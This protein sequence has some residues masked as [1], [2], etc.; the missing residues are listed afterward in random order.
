MITRRHLLLLSGFAGT[1]LVVQGIGFLCGLLLLRVM[2]VTQ[3][4]IYTLAVSL[5]GVVAM[6]AD[7]GLTSAMLPQGAPCL[8]QPARLTQLLAQARTLSWRFGL[9]S[10]LLWPPVLVQLLRRQQVEPGQVVALALLVGVTAWLQ[11]QA[12]LAL[13][14]VRLL[15]HTRWQQLF[16]LTAQSIRLLVLLLISAVGASAALGLGGWRLD[17]TA[18]CAISLLLAAVSWLAVERHLRRHLG[19]SMR[20]PANAQ[21][22][23]HDDHRAGLLH[24]VRR[25]GPNTV[26]YI[27]NGQ[28]AVWLIGWFGHAERVA[29][30]GALGRLGVLFTVL[31][32]VSSALLLPYFA[33]RTAVAD[34]AA[35]LQLVHGFFALLLLTLA[36]AAAWL[37]QLFLWVLGPRYAGLQA[38][39]I[40]MVVA[41]TL[42]TW[43]GTVYSI[44]CSR[45]W[46]VP[47]MQSAPAGLGAIAFTAVLV[48]VSTVRGSYLIHLSSAV[49]AL[50]ISSAYL[51]RQLRSGHAAAPCAHEA[52]TTLPA[53]SPHDRA[54]QPSHA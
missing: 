22:H 45:G 7:L 3:Y 54:P 11:V 21:S 36:G 43:G 14:L 35:G 23:A 46:V 17:A 42:A 50:L 6:L 31:G 24:F 32:S 37:P 10:L 9:V 4:G 20:E 12:G 13:T 16:D 40:W 26:Y 15:G 41:S 19:G 33:R 53:A 8:T 2:T 30:V 44:G 39:L 28:I 27:V 51:Q 52:A 1:Q 34:V 48:D 5:T 29:E 18:A 49:A 47:I 38:E 25:Q